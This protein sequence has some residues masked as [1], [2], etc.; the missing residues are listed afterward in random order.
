MADF[1]RCCDEVWTVSEDSA[2][3]LRSYGYRND[4]TDVQN[5][6]EVRASSPHLETAARGEFGLGEA[7]ILL[8][9][10][11]LDYKKNLHML[12]E[13]A[14]LLKKEEHAF[15]LVFAGQAGIR[16]SSQKRL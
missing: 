16:R 12:L 4:I 7:P 9:V 3:T 1:Y 15:Q 2:Q 8:Y 5:G 13:A 6:T 14:A 11:Q 10:G